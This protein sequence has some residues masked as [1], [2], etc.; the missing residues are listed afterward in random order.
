MDCVK[1]ILASGMALLASQGLAAQAQE[2]PPAGTPRATEDLTVVGEPALLYPSVGQM[3]D[4]MHERG[5]VMVGLRFEHSRMSGA[6]RHGTQAVS[7]A[8]LFA[9]GYMMR[10]ENMTMDMVMLDLMFAPS[11]QVTLTLS[12]QYMWNRMRMVGLDDPMGGS[13][14]MPDMEMSAHGF[15][16]TFAAA[17]LRLVRRPHLKAH[18]TLGVWI[19]TGA[20][21]RKDGMGMLLDY[22]M[23]PGSGTWDIEPSA[24]VSGG[25]GRLGWGVLA[26]YRLPVERRNGVGFRFGSRARLSGWLSYLALPAL[27]LTA[28]AEYSRQGRIHGEYTGLHNMMMSP[29][30]Q[31]A[32][33]GGQSLT[34]SIGANWQLGEER[35]APQLGVELGV[36]L[37]R[38]LHGI[39]MP[40][41]WRVTAAIRQMF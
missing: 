15:G 14:P 19:P 23:Q 2:L 37:Y 10:G 30:D 39:Q 18:A 11:D 3:N 26:G 22:S 16:D 29:S 38:K 21:G 4:H 32:N 8:D 6:P 24:T 27:G 40:Q 25:E 13:M 31:P 41:R 7:D 12:P 33:Y 28:R 17:S 5:E 20:V 1:A 9:A 36:P 34:G 35:R